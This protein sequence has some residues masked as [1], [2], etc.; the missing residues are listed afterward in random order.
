M[1]RQ[2]PTDPPQE[3]LTAA[4]PP[5]KLCWPYLPNDGMAQAE[6]C[7]ENHGSCT[8]L[9]SVQHALSHSECAGHLLVTPENGV[10][11]VTSVL[12]QANSP[13]Q[14]SNL[15]GGAIFERTSTQAVQP[16]DGML[17]WPP[18]DLAEGNETD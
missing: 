12:P 6:E 7:Q 14:S 15:D 1:R 5:S 17:C 11:Q 8:G 10:L 2:A 13:A 16:G 4:F 3:P 9:V 18:K